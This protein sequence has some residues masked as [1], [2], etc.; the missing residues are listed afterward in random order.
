MRGRVKSDDAAAAVVVVVLP[1]DELGSE[2][3]KRLGRVSRS[4]VSPL[5]SGRFVAVSFASLR[6]SW[7]G[8]IA[9]VIDLVF[10]SWISSFSTGRVAAVRAWWP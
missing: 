6:L 10:G 4:S 7:T 2:V 5:E 1:T 9:C 8:T 3:D